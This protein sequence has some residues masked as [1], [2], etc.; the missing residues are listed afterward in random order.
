MD[1]NCNRK[2]LHKVLQ[3]SPS[4]GNTRGKI[5]T[6][7]PVKLPCKTEESAVKTD[8]SEHSY[9]RRVLSQN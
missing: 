7:R 1:F 5:W 4:G 9:A 8:Q 2:I 6:I 3:S